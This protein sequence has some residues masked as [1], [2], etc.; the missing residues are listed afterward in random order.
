MK[1]EQIYELLYEIVSDID[2]VDMKMKK[3]HFPVDENNFGD[4]NFLRLYSCSKQYNVLKKVC[5]NIIPKI[6]TK[7]GLNEDFIHQFKIISSC[8]PAYDFD[9]LEICPEAEN[10]KLKYIKY[11]KANKINFNNNNL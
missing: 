5:S 3:V 4:K 2:E 1:K 9:T 11:L 10:L 6:E 8:I 7:K